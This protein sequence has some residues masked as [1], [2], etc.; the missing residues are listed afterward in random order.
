M[1]TKGKIT[2]IVGLNSLGSLHLAEMLLSKGYTVH[3]VDI[4]TDLPHSKGTSEL[5]Q[6]PNFSLHGVNLTLPDDIIQLI[7]QKR[8]DEIYH[9]S[10]S[11]ASA[12][13]LYSGQD[14]ASGHLG[15]ALHILEAIRSAMPAN[16]TKFCHI[17]SAPLYYLLK[18]RSYKTETTSVDVANANVVA[19]LQPYHTTRGYREAHSMFACN[20]ISFLHDD[21]FTL[22]RAKQ[23]LSQTITHS[24]VETVLGIQR[25]FYLGDL[26]SKYDWGH[27]SDYADAVWL[28]LQQD[29]PADYVLTTGNRSSVRDFVRLA[30]AVLGITVEF[31]GKGLREKG[32]VIDVDDNVLD[33]L[34]LNTD[35]ELI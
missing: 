10:T 15:I 14:A 9:F 31:S 30:F 2:L 5:I 7:N 35:Y 24:I 29:T 34:G 3:G 4:Y 32:V 19:N 1:E 8:P 26:S 23:T 17:F 11:L 13:S 27:A 18:T 16:K 12:M 25:T 22:V 20:G 6:H 33:T 28:M 21:F